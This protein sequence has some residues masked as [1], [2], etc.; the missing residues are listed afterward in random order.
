MSQPPHL[1]KI[2]K[3]D[4]ILYVSGSSEPPFFDFR[5]GVRKMKK[6]LA[7][8]RKITDDK[9]LRLIIEGAI[10]WM[11]EIL[12][13]RLLFGADWERMGAA[14]WLTVAG[15]M[16]LGMPLAAYLDSDKSEISK[17]IAQR[18]V[19][20][21]AAMRYCTVMGTMFW[22]ARDGIKTAVAFIVLYAAMVIASNIILARQTSAIKRL[23]DTRA[24]S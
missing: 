16:F 6:L 4:I 1:R 10:C 18:R 13:W 3:H 14:V 12:L 15:I 17:L 11:A 24:Q 2:A 19:I 5:K 9:A 21:V 7:F 20:H 23:D 22:Y 8:A